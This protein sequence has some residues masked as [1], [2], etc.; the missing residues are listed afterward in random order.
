L[1]PTRHVLSLHHLHLALLALTICGCKSTD[2]SVQRDAAAQTLTPTSPLHSRLPALLHQLEAA[3]IEHHVPG[4]GIAVVH[5]DEIILCTGLG[6]ANIEKHTKATGDT[7]FAIGSSSKA[8]TATAIAMLV[9]EGVMD[10][11]DR[12]QEHL[13]DFHLYDKEANEKV[14]IRDLLCHRTGLSRMGLLWAGGALSRDEIL[15][16]VV[17]AEPSHTFG[18]DFN[19]SN[20][21]FIAAGHAAGKAAGT[22]WETLVQQRIFT[23]LAMNNASLSV[24]AAQK[25]PELATGYM[26]D[27]IDEVFEIDPMRNIDA[28]G[29]A[30]SINASPRDMAN[31]IRFQLAR[32]EF[33]G[34]RLLS[35]EQ[36]EETWTPHVPIMADVSYALG[37]MVGKF[38]GSRLVEHGGNIDGYSAHVAFLPDDDLG[39]VLLMNVSFSGLQAAADSIILGTLLEKNANDDGEEVEDF[40]PYLG[41]YIANFGPFNDDRFTVQVKDGKLAVDVPGQTTYELNPPDEEGKRAFSITDTIAVSFDRNGDGEVTVLKMYQAGLTFECPREGA[42]VAGSVTLDDVREY[43]GTYHVDK[44]AIDC[45]VLMQNGRLAIDVPGQM[46]YALHPP[47]DDGKWV[48]RATDTIALKFN[49][50]EDGDVE[51]LTMYQAGTESVLPRIGTPDASMIASLDEVM[52]LKWKAFGGDKL[53][54]IKTLHMTGSIRFVNQAVAGTV[55]TYVQGLTHFTNIMDLG[56]CGTIMSVVAGDRGWSASSFDPTQELKGKYLHGSQRMHPLIIAADWREIADDISVQGVKQYDGRAHYAVRVKFDDLKSTVYIDVETGLITGEDLVIVTPGIGN[57]PMTA[58]YSEYRDVS[59]V[60][61][62][63]RIEIKNDFHGKTVIQFDDFD[64]NVELPDDA[65]AEQPAQIE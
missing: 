32:G 60:K 10:W 53:D 35:T 14:T 30:G 23:P 64:L 25:N 55:T 61:L 6:E 46:T 7:I 65:F 63:A 15:A 51:S 57:L 11:D 38:Q 3:R 16:A 40:T 17:N 4:L 43:L 31:W 54:S 56:R 26:W 22:D 24:T 58:R 52:A 37:W 5:N 9:D 41:K 45:E 19:Y 33:E 48:F 8:F 13:P 39:F 12:V 29:P 36:I 2:P 44:L 20:I 50:G 34:A 27:D 62:P 18:E 47:D 42:E 59:G 49:H 28:G 1:K 21:N